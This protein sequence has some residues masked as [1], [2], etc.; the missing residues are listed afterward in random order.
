[1]RENWVDHAK[2]IGIILVVFGHVNRGLESAGIV[3]PGGAYKLVD[4]LIY[5]FHMPL[6][7]FLSGLFFVKSIES[8]GTWRFVGSK[9]DTLV[10]PF[11]IWSTLQGGI[12]ILLSRYTNG[13]ATVSDMLTMYV[14]PHDQF[15][16]LYALF[17]NAVL[18]ALL[19]WR[20]AYRRGWPLLI[21][22]I[23]VVLYL[24]QDRIG[25]RFNVDFITRFAVFYI[26]G[27]C[28]MPLVRRLETV[29]MGTIALVVVVFAVLEYVFHITFGLNYERTGVFSLVLAFFGIAALACVSVQTARSHVDWLGQLGRVSMQIYLMHILAGSGTRIILSKALHVHNWTVHAVVGTAVGIVAP[30]IAWQLMQRFRMTWLFNRPRAG[31]MR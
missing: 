21:L 26:A 3:M 22:A 13:N 19:Y 16:F 28:F 6:F 29:G 20:E 31:G 1:M 9:V 24:L 25:E 18:F 8:R 10:Y 17:M 14:R 5:A 30:I 4:S 27:A 11:V 12:Q 15:W 7:F 2:G 23:T